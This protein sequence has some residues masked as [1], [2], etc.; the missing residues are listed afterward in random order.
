MSEKE[1]WGADWTHLPEPQENMPKTAAIILAAGRGRRMGTKIQKQFLSLDGKPLLYYSLK[2]F[3][4][5]PVEE[6]ILVTGQEEIEYCRKEIIERYGFYKVSQIVAGGEERYHS[7]YEGLRAL[8][9]SKGF[10]KSCYVLIHDGA[11]PFSNT[12]MI[13]RA[14][15][16]AVRFGAC[17]VGMPVKDT[18]KISDKEGFAN[19]TPD[20]S[21]VWMI[22]TPQAFYYPLIREAYDKLMSQK[23]FQTG[24]TDD[25]MVV[26]T[27]TNHSVKLTEGSYENIKVTTPEDMEIAFAILKRDGQHR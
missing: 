5:S 6:V 7:V 1:R 15:T 13:I 11:R 3:E 18:I 27:M 14:I 4:E 23:E 22:Q 17:A 20:R 2:A 24:I 19:V 16:D 26:E 10:K 25:A 8:E 12:K 9:K 21:L